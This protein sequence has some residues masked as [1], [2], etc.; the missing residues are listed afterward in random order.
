MFTHGK[1]DLPSSVVVMHTCDNRLCCN[2]EH[3]RSGSNDEN[4]ADMAAKGRASQGDEHWTRRDPANLLRGEQVK[5]SKLKAE[6]IPEIW[7]MRAAG[8]DM[9]TIAK[10]FGVTKQKIWQVLHGR[11]WSHISKE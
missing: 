10:R 7:R 5:G 9:P 1:L 6:D 11:A 8:L 4:M 2:P 3:L